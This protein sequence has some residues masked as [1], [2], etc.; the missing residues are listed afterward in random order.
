MNRQHIAVWVLSSIITTMPIAASAQSSLSTVDKSYLTELNSLLEKSQN[1]L[2]LIFS[3]QQKIEVGKDN[4]FLLDNGE[5]IEFL[6]DSIRGSVV[7]VKDEFRQETYIDFGINSMASGINNYCPKYI[8]N[9][10]N[11]LNANK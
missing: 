11:Y 2:V 8:E 1:P 5:S 10:K 6:I 3:D 4:C 7:N 9:V